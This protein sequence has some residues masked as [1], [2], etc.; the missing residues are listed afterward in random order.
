MTTFIILLQVCTAL[1]AGGF[2]SMMLYEHIHKKKKSAGGRPPTASLASGGKQELAAPSHDPSKVH[3]TGI[4]TTQPLPPT[5]SIE[6]TNQ[7]KSRPE[8][9]QPLAGDKSELQSSKIS[10]N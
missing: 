4:P 10:E 5:V 2:L 8:D 3:D 6:P 7:E 1:L 9:D